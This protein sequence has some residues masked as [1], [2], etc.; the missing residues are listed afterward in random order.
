MYSF[1]P[2]C[3]KRPSENS[4]SPAPDVCRSLLQICA[5]RLWCRTSNTS[6]RELKLTSSVKALQTQ[7]FILRRSGSESHLQRSNSLESLSFFFE[8][9]NLKDSLLQTCFSPGR[10]QRLILFFFLFFL[11]SALWNTLLILFLAKRY[12]KKVC[13]Y[14]GSGGLNRFPGCIRHPAASLYT[15]QSAEGTIAHIH[16]PTGVVFSWWQHTGGY[17]IWNI[18]EKNLTNQCHESHGW[19]NQT[20]TD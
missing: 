16:T 5:G 1:T 13:Y 2:A 17:Y 8:C 18:W 19:G 10:A 11:P 15:F 20:Y 6:T 12:I 7:A 9:R 3:S 14:S 4:L